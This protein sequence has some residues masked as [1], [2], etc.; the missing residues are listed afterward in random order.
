MA[1][2][3]ITLWGMMQYML[4][5]EQDLFAG[6]SE[7]PSDIDTDVLID[8]II[9]QGGEFEV[10]YA[11]P[12]FLK[13]RIT[14]W[15]KQHQRTFQKWIDALKLEFEPLWNYDRHEIWTDINRDE[16]QD[17][18]TVTSHDISI[19]NGYANND[20][21]SE[22]LTNENEIR[23]A[24]SDKTLSSEN[25][26]NSATRTDSDSNS[27]TT[28]TVSAYNSSVYEPD[29]QSVTNADSDSVTVVSGGSKE[30]GAEHDK[31]IDTTATGSHTTS[32][33]NDA[34]TTGNVDNRHTIS[35]NTGTSNNV[36]NSKHEG[37]LYG[38]I[39][40]T[41]SSQMLMEY[42]DAMQWNIYQ[43]ITDMFIAE[44]TIPVYI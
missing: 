43:H 7:L 30:D 28:N 14:G 6:F 13:D 24:D 37:H 10:I 44:F 8:T 17:T 2:A 9:R 11:N 40:V 38:N 26:N 39:G 5:H 21:S 23:V 42:L 12:D 35:D 31:N 33:N 34:G 32:S 29:N 3:K 41:T 27:T 19:G 20:G 18:N 16:R 15:T 25:I 36:G 1:I 22:L 4:D